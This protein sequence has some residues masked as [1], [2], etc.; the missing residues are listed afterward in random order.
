MVF[1]LPHVVRE[2]LWEPNLALADERSQKILKEDLCCFNISCNTLL[3]LG[4]LKTVLC[5]RVCPILGSL[6]R[7]WWR[8]WGCSYQYCI[9]VFKIDS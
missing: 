7:I 9:C 6:C 3:L 1:G 8:M 4:R 5:R 2:A